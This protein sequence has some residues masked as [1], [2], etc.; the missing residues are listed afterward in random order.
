MAVCGSSLGQCVGEWWWEHCIW[1]ARR[2]RICWSRFLTNQ[3][4]KDTC[5]LQA[6]VEK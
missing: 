1:E 3:Q 5:Q 2:P 4:S 6:V